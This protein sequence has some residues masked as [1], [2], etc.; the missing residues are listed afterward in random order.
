MTY[1]QNHV[2]DRQSLTWQ[3]N[4]KFATYDEHLLLFSLLQI[5]K[6]QQK[7]QGA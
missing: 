7:K 4:T 1:S 3:N 5:Y 6:Y 2:L